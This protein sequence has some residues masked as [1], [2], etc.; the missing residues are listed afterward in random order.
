MIALEIVS[1]FEDILRQPSLV[2]QLLPRRRRNLVDHQSG[3]SQYSLDQPIVSS[4]STSLDQ[5]GPINH[6]AARRHCDR[7]LPRRYQPLTPLDSPFAL[8]PSCRAAHSTERDFHVS[9]LNLCFALLQDQ[10]LPHDPLPNIKHIIDDRLE[11]AR[12]VVRLCNVDVVGL[13]GRGGRVEVGD[14]DKPVLSVLVCV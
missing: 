9:R 11:M 6:T 10:R 12:G 14:F 2:S 1:Q 7:R 4:G 3:A 13:A 8:H 5:I